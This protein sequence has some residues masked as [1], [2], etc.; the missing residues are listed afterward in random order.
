LETGSKDTTDRVPRPAL[1]TVWRVLEQEAVLVVLDAEEPR[2]GRTV[3]EGSQSEASEDS[4][5][6]L[7][8]VVAAFSAA[9][10]ALI[11]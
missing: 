8:A 5:T 6:A 11:G 10:A 3:T 9:G 7:L 1:I 4:I 2:P